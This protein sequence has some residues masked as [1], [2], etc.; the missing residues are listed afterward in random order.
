MG[1]A[2]VGSFLSNFAQGYKTGRE[3]VDDRKA[4]EA[5]A[6]Y[7]DAAAGSLN[8]EIDKERSALDAINRAY[9]FG[10]QPQQADQ[11]PSAGT[12]TDASMPTPEQAIIQPGQESGTGTPTPMPGVDPQKKYDLYRSQIERF[13]RE[14]KARAYAAEVRGDYTNAQ[15]IRSMTVPEYLSNQLLRESQRGLSLVMAGRDDPEKVR[16][17]VEILNQVANAYPSVRNVRFGAVDTPTGPQL[18]MQVWGPDGRPAS[19]KPTLIDINQARAILKSGLSPKTVEKDVNELE[20]FVQKQ[21][22]GMQSSDGSSGGSGSSG[23]NGATIGQFGPD[24]LYGMPSITKL[25]DGS[26]VSPEMGLRFYPV[27]IPSAQND[28]KPTVQYKAEKLPGFDQFNEARQAAIQNQLDLL[29]LSIGRS[30][31][32]S[33]GGGNPLDVVLNG[34]RMYRDAQQNDTKQGD[35]ATSKKAP[36]ANTTKTTNTAGVNNPA[37]EV[38]SPAVQRARNR[39]GALQAGPVAGT[40]NPDVMPG[41]LPDIIPPRPGEQGYE[42]PATAEGQ[43]LVEAKKRLAEMRKKAKD[44]PRFYGPRVATAQNRVRLLEVMS[45]PKF[46]QYMNKAEEAAKVDPRFTLGEGAMGRIRSLSVRPGRDGGRR[47]NNILMEI[48]P[49]YRNLNLALQYIMKRDRAGVLGRSQEVRDLRAR[50]RN[51]RKQLIEAA[52]PLGP[53]QARGFIQ[54]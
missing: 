19:D 38:V 34:G 4:K 53:N 37:D 30:G 2:A 40:Q 46:Q 9:G 7:R 54:R 29:G 18:T 6:N 8:F 25:D 17:G 26:F 51:R 11:T 12:Q 44:N 48:D 10:D 42:G 16:A 22:V 43:Q 47:M 36:P 14:Q 45:S 21:A 39:P 5:L 32:V 15:T 35:V 20:A 23:I 52:K 13:R 28:G 3:L 1:G 50:I 31:V 41:D 27:E 49:T 24:K 33:G